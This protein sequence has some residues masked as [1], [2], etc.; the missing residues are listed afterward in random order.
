MENE[1]EQSMYETKVSGLMPTSIEKATYVASSFSGDSI[2]QELRK[3]HEKCNDNWKNIWYA[4]IRIC[5]VVITIGTIGLFFDSL[6][7]ILRHCEWTEG[8]FGDLHSPFAPLYIAIYESLKHMMNLKIVTLWFTYALL[9]IPVLGLIY[10]ILKVI[11]EWMEAWFEKKRL[12]IRFPYSRLE[13]QEIIWN[14]K[15]MDEF[16]SDLK[17]LGDANYRI[18]EEP[19]KDA[20]TIETVKNSI[21][22]KKSYEFFW[23]DERPCELMDYQNKVID[24][25]Q[26]DAYYDIGNKLNV[27]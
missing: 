26:M 1:M 17:S 5:D 10:I 6:N 22:R 11:L 15:R 12:I 24:F 19:K 27:M 4:F 14:Y 3:K 13:E 23:K 7:T 16:I 2:K 21:G 18:I 9:S 8:L 20:L 25:S